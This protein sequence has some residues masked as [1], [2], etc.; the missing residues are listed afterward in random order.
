[1]LDLV[2]TV[3]DQHGCLIVS[4]SSFLIMVLL[5]LQL[6][7]D[8]VGS[9]SRSI[10]SASRAV[11]RMLTRDDSVVVVDALAADDDEDGDRGVAPHPRRGR[12]CERC[13]K[14]GASRSDVVAVMRS[15]R[16]LPA[17]D[18]DD[19][20]GGGCAAMW[21]EVDE[22][23]ESKV[24]SEAELREAFYVF[25]RDEDGFVDAG[26][27]WNVL[28]R[29]GMADGAKHEE[30]CRRMIAAHDG[31]GDGRISFPEFRAMMEN[32]L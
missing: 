10:L 30:D 17:G 7:V 28:R 18:E 2:E 4:V 25:D 11:V 29:L 3:F 6:L 16:L 32:A 15:L 31:D 8:D 20:G 21:E 1:M 12:H 24:A 9:A 5:Q 27:L 23:L 13:A 14:R 26:E 22:L 19:G